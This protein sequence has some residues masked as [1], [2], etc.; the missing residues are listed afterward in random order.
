MQSLDMGFPRLEEGQET[1]E[2]LKQVVDYLYILLE[3][4]RFMLSNLGVQNFNEKELEDLTAPVYKSIGSLEGALL[5]V[6]ATA[7][8]AQITAA[9]AKGAAT[10]AQITADGASVTASS[11][12]GKAASLEFTVNGLTVRNADGSTTIDGNK[13][14]SGTIEGVTVSGVFI[15]GCYINGGTIVSGTSEP[16]KI[17]DGKIEVG[18]SA[19]RAE[20]Y[21]DGIRAWLD[22]HFTPLKIRS[23]GGVSVDAPTGTLYLGTENGGNDVSIGGAGHDIR[24]N[25]NV[26]ING[27]LQG[28]AGE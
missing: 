21:H 9:N 4:L 7:E 23:Y 16:V 1:G 19:H 18:Y 26:Y 27:V 24:L 12:A 5:Q 28:G 20:L 2:A 11:A 22:G 17:S 14:R 3:N 10:Q 15:E 25:G 8:G 13:I 6:K